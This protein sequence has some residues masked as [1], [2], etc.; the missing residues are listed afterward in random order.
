MGLVNDQFIDISSNRSSLGNDTIKD[1]E[2]RDLNSLPA[3]PWEL[4]PGGYHNPGTRIQA[5]TIIES[6]LQT[7]AWIERERSKRFDSGYPSS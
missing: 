5:L 1:L 4:R 7:W 3:L 6:N 2:E